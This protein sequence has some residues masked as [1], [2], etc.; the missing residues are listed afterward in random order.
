MKHLSIIYF[1]IYIHI[2]AQTEGADTTVYFN[3]IYNPDII[4]NN[5]IAFP[6]V[7]TLDE[8]YTFA[9]SKFYQLPSLQEV[10]TLFFTHIN[11]YGQE[12]WTRHIYQEDFLSSITSSD[13][14]V[15]NNNGNLILVHV[16]QY[17][18]DSLHHIRFAQYDSEANLLLEQI[19]D[20]FNAF[21]WQ[22]IATKDGGY[23][24]AG[25]SYDGYDMS[26]IKTDQY[27][28][29]QWRKQYDLGIFLRHSTS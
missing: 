25:A 11:K 29:I 20:D 8:G 1:L 21:P 10:Q 7:N 15:Q 17:S 24:I 4:T 16:L 5:I 3:K 2:Y 13:C 9:G 26:L 23:A 19:Y 12:Q 28:F 22:L 14:L 6:I 18:P 27:G